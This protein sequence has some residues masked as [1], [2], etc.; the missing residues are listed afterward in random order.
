MKL[1]SYVI[2]GRTTLLS[3]TTNDIFSVVDVFLLPSLSIISDSV[4]IFA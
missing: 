4:L 1:I 2:D 3:I